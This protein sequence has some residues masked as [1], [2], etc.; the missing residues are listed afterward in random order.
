[1]PIQISP[2]TERDIPGAITAIQEAFAQDPYNLWVFNDRSK[3][4]EIGLAG[5]IIPSFPS[6]IL[7]AMGSEQ[8]THLKM[9]KNGEQ[10]LLALR[11]NR[12]HINIL[13]STSR[14]TWR[15]ARQIRAYHVMLTN[16][17]LLRLLE[18][19]PSHHWQN[20][21]RLFQLKLIRIQYVKSA[22]LTGRNVC[23]SHDGHASSAVV[24][25]VHPFAML[26]P[27]FWH[28]L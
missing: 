4:R 16:S 28:T 1:M 24:R 18:A 20:R 3:V 5:P 22:S 25:L 2:L 10:R 12:S 11:V 19:M 8:S 17:F 27:W 14:H 26:I 9:R 6:L 7:H 15:V 21:D 23:R 13:V